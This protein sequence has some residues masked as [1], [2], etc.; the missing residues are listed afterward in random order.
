MSEEQQ[1]F[2]ELMKRVIKVSP[3]ELKRRLDESKTIKPKVEGKVKQE[4]K[5]S[6]QS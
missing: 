5:G 2:D 4:T 1:R 6:S 3:E